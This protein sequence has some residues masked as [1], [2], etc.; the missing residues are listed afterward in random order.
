MAK[1]KHHDTDG[2]NSGSK[3][4]KTFRVLF[5]NGK[6]L[7]IKA[8]RF[9]VIADDFQVHFYDEQGVTMQDAF[10]ARSEVAAIVPA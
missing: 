10:I 6:E 4:Q 3:K 2:D 7:E 9:Q 5:N 1:S 8:E